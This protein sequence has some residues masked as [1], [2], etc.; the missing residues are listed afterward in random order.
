ML[1]LLFQFFPVMKE[2]DTKVHYVFVK[3]IFNYLKTAM[4]SFGEDMEMTGYPADEN[5]SWYN[6]LYTL[7]VCIKSSK[8]N[9][10]Y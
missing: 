5:I 8:N 6:P 2:I 1:T 7:G 3:Q 9:F 4:H 10:L